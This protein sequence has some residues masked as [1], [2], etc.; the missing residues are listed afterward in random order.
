MKHVLLVGFLLAGPFAA[1]GALAHH[2]FTAEYDQN[3]TVTLRGPLKEIQMTNPHGWIVLDVKGDDGQVVTWRVETG[4]TNTLMRAGLRKTDFVPGTEIIVKGFQ[5]K[6]G[7][8]IANGR[9]V[10][11]A[12]GRDFFLGTSAPGA[13]ER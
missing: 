7:R 6:S 12:D 1:G 8:P 3:K 2:A 9:E 5:A 11:F 10:T 13:G 4:P